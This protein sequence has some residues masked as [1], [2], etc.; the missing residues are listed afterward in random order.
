VAAF[1]GVGVAVSSAMARI[2]AKGAP[3]A[4][5]LALS[6]CASGIPDPGLTAGVGT[7]AIDPSVTASVPQSPGPAGSGHDDMRLDGEAIARV[8]S[9][10]PFSG[11]TLPW[12]NPATGSKGEVFAVLERKGETG[13]ICRDFSAFRAAYDG[14]RNHGGTVCMDEAGHWTLTAF[15]PE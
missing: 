10:V 13:R 1:W 7:S 12:E 14:L 4:A 15:S 11:R 5:A 2:I 8:V 6:A 9:A 3:L